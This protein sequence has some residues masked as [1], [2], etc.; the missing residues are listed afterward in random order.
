MFISN[1][2]KKKTVEK[3]SEDSDIHNHK[4]RLTELTDASDQKP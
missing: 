3:H 1:N 2:N 4:Y